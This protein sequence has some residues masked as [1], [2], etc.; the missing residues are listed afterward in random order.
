MNHT[1]LYSFINLAVSCRHP[2]L[3][4]LLQLWSRIG[5]VLSHRRKVALRQGLDGRLVGF[6]V[7]SVALCNLNPLNRR[8]NICHSRFY[9][10]YKKSAVYY[11]S[12]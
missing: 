2:L 5:S 10:N 6:V 8:L 4:L 7:Q 3:N 1:P 9:V 11:Y 12:E